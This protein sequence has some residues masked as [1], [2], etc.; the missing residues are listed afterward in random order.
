MVEV[1]NGVKNWASILDDNT[2]KQ[3]EMLSRSEV[4]CGH[5]ALMPDAH[6]GMGATVG[7][8]IPTKNAVIPAA[9]GVDIGCGMIAV[10]TGL[11][12]EDLPQDL[13]SLHA[14]IDRSVPAGV[15]R[16]GAWGPD[17]KA[18]R[19]IGSRYAAW[20]QENPA[21]ARLEE[22]RDRSGS[23]TTRAG[24][25]VG[26]LGSGN[27][28]VEMGLDGDDALWVVIHSGSRGVGNRLAMHHIEIAQKL[29]QISGVNLEDKDLAFLVQD[30]P[31]FDD[32]IYDMEWAQRY[33][34]LN[35]EV[36]MDQVLAQVYR[37]IRDAG[38]ITRI[39]CHHNFTQR[40]THFGQDVWL[41]RKGAIYAG[42]GAPGVVPGSMATGIFI[43]SGKGNPD[44]YLSSAHGAGRVRSRGA[45]RRELKL[46]GEDGLYGMMDGITWNVEHAK[47]LIDEHPLAYKDI[48]QVMQ[49]QADLCEAVGFIRPVLNY[50]G[51]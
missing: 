18:Y 26:T 45:A 10:N 15:G 9:I 2:K 5:V 32:Y 23:L 1:I 6:I 4:I 42:E 38:E 16:G 51:A 31:E 29:C 8:V 21:S 27:H 41:T 3:A 35:R 14:D 12:K 40:E 43:T 49:D 7:S 36:M 19:L 24:L 50:K 34:L 33:A 30:T 44:S 20:L 39:N 11:S 48:Q 47:G 25:Q 22:I 28:F 13:A 37:S 17:N 46:D